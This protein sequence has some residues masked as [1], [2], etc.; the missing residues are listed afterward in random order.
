M[1]AGIGNLV[2]GVQEGGDQKGPLPAVNGPRSIE[3]LDVLPDIADP[4]TV[5][6][7]K[8]GVREILRHI[9][10]LVHRNRVVV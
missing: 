1:T 2:H 7:G 3:S 6:P 4:G 5:L 8:I 10:F 9:V